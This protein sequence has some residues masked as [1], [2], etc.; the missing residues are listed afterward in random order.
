MLIEEEIKKKS[1]LFRFSYNNG[2]EE[3]SEREKCL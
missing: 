1:S 2:S 3:K